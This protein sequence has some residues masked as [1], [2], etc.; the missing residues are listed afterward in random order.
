MTARR[1]D[2][3][4]R[5]DTHPA[6]THSTGTPSSGED[7]S[8]F[9][10]RLPS[11]PRALRAAVARGGAGWRCS[12][13]AARC[14]AARRGWWPSRLCDA[15]LDTARAYCIT[16]IYGMP[17]TTVGLGSVW[18]LGYDQT[19]YPHARVGVGG[20]ACKQASGQSAAT[21]SACPTA[22]ASERA[23]AL[24]KRYK[25]Q[26]YTSPPPSLYY[27]GGRGECMMII[28]IGRHGTERAQAS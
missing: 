24:N 11:A 17:K 13:D 16:L 14:D 20:P 8:I 2:R 27:K 6:P 26:L 22:D 5:G 23:S 25:L 12:R 19:I 7:A 9:I 21:E 4:G 28:G 15:G 1:C 10:A 18:V 3:T